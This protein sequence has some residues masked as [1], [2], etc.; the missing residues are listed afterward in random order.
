[1]SEDE[2]KALAKQVLNSV[3]GGM[4]APDI[5]ELAMLL[6]SALV[7]KS[8]SERREE[9][10]AQLEQGFHAAVAEGKVRAAF[11]DEVI[12]EGAEATKQ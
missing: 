8:H 12:A 9:I 3:P 10:V 11:R 7:F 5:A 1:M 6:V 2:I 4:H